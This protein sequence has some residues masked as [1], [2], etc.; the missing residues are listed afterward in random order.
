M[1]GQSL[2]CGGMSGSHCQHVDVN[3]KKLTKAKLSHGELSVFLRR[4]LKCG[5]HL[6]R[7]HESFEIRFD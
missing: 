3:V 5:M 1:R 4:N 2:P 7:P 6:G